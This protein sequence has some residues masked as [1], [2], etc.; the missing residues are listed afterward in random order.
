MPFSLKVNA[1][2]KLQSS[3]PET[4]GIWLND[5][6]C[7]CEKVIPFKEI[8]MKEN[9]FEN[10]SIDSFNLDILLRNLTMQMS[11]NKNNASAKLETLHGLKDF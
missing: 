1:H 10:T 4:K 3:W 5:L 2:S 11:L 7:K 6:W 8:H 9:G